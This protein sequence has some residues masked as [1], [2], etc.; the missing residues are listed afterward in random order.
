[1][2][3]PAIDIEA[4]ARLRRH[5]GRPE[6]LLTA[7]EPVIVVPGPAR[8]S[9]RARAV[10]GRLAAPVVE[11][12]RLELARAV[13]REQAALHAELHEL[14]ADLDRTRTA[15]AAELAALHEQLR[16]RP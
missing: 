5:L 6:P 3:H 9:D 7:I 10:A 8:F 11:R 2:T 16:D 4:V 15:H 1:M 12:A 13:E 14:R